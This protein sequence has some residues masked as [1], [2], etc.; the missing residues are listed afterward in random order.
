MIRLIPLTD[1]L[2]HKIII[3]MK[4]KGRVVDVQAAK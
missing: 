2:L 4:R 1:G 3:I